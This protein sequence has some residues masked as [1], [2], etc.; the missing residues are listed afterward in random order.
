MKT[1]I[2]IDVNTIVAVIT[3]PEKIITVWLGVNFLEPEKIPSVHVGA[4]VMEGAY[5]LKEGLFF[6]RSM[7]V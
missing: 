1:G 5:L 2:F 4:Y 6:E 3:A 7:I